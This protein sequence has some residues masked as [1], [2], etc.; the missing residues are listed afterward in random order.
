M[1]VTFRIEG[2]AVDYD[3]DRTF[4]NVGNI[5]GRDL[6][7]WLGYSLGPYLGEALDPGDL[8]AHCRRRLW[9]EPRN[10]DPAVPELV[11]AA[12]RA[13]LLGR[14]EGYLRRRCE[15]LL[16]LAETAGDRTI[17]FG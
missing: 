7:V 12:G 17:H 4:V 13:I 10:I 15:D 9:D 5:T 6:L 1:S 16:R 14:P 11:L 2:V 8:A 3:D